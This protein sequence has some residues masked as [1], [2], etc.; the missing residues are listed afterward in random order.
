MKDR[1]GGYILI[2]IGVVLF[3]IA[4]FMDIGVNVG[5][6]F[7]VAN[8]SLM[9]LRTSLL[10]AAGVLTICG[11]IIISAPSNVS[12]RHARAQTKLL[13]L[14]AAY[15]G[16]ASEEINNIVSEIGDESPLLFADEESGE[17]NYNDNL[18]PQLPD[19]YKK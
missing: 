5:Q 3:L 14:I 18:P 1:S 6:D 19:F 15:N 13:S 10:I 11:V 2:G 12:L 16:A 7:K 9:N 17:E 8:L 4:V